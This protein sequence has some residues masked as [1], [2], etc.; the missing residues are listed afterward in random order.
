MTTTDAATTSAIALRLELLGLPVPAPV[1]QSEADRLMSPILARQ[2]ELSRRLAH[3][4][5]AADQRI[6][7][8]LDSYLEGAAVT[9]KLPRS[10]FVLDQP[11]LARALSLPEDATSFTSDY[12]ESYRVL[13]G[14]LHNPR[15]DRRTIVLPESE[16]DR[17]LRAADSVL[18]RN[19]ANVV[20]LGDE[21]AVHARA[22]ELGLNIS[23][24]RI[25]S[26]ND[27]QL[28]E[29]YAT[30]FARLRAKKGVTL[31]QAREKVQDVSYFGTM[32]VHM[33][34]AD[35]MVSGAVH[36][37]AH[38]IVPSFQIIK[39][40]PGTSIVSS[41]FLM[42]L[43]DRVLVYGDCAVN[44]E[45]TAEQLADIAISSAE[46]ARQF[47]VEPRVAML[48]F[49]TGTSG[50]G[51]DVD[52]VRT[53]TELVRQKAPELA[54]EGPIQ[55]DAAIDPSVAATKA[56]GSAVA[57]RANVFIFPD[58]S[59]GNIGYKAVQR[60]S[61]AVAVGPILQGLNKPVNDLSRGALVE[62]I[63]NTVAITAVQAQG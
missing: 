63:I 9:P 33:G 8:F 40:K 1:K 38:T 39:T 51:A 10:T 59:S 28:L 53:A 16:D 60:S 4:P 15:N 20:L 23:G 56:P 50:K 3:R 42:L 14:V 35:G 26:V 30:E 57:G 27:E 49:S 52:K 2:R 37:T 54:V 5:C 41:V 19:V 21:N 34:D 6:Q 18:R 43:E 12:V 48:S 31:E 55:Y 11:G 25:V 58:L 24:A 62:D 45:P 61:G 47:G 46:T 13:G 29:K 17:V 7:T 36:T 32:M 44:P 22:T